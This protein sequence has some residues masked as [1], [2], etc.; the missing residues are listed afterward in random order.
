MVD[1]SA[2]YNRSH[3]RAVLRRAEAGERFR[4]TVDGAPVAQIEPIE[5]YVWVSG[6]VMERAVRNAPA[7][8]ALLDDVAVMREQLAE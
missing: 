2:R 1:V 8:T 4:V 5:R 3:T 7:D 6:S